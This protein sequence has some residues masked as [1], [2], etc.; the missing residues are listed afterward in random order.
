MG[1]AMKTHGTG[2][3]HRKGQTQSYPSI[4]QPS[5]TLELEVP[6]TGPGPEVVVDEGCSGKTARFYL[7]GHPCIWL[8]EKWRR[9]CRISG[10]E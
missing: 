6:S 2:Y 10:E 4:P 3:G 8:A 9:R 1:T 5:E 7:G